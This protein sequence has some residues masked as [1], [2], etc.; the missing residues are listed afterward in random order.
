MEAPKH[1]LFVG[2]LPS[3]LT[4]EEV[5]SVFATYGNC[6][7]CHIMG[8]KATSGQACAFIVYEDADAAESAISA[9]NNVYSF[10]EDGTPPVTV[11]WARQGGGKG[12]GGDKGGGKGGPPAHSQYSAPQYAA[13]QS[14][15]GGYSKPAYQQQQAP[16][17]GFNAP[18][19]RGHGGHGGN[20]YAAGGVNP[21]PPPVHAASQQKKLFVG[22]LPLD[23]QDEAINMVFSHYGSVTNIHIMSGKSRSGQSCAFVE[24]G[25]PIE[26][27]TAI[28][29]LNE[30]YEIRPGE[31]PI[32]VK[33]ATPSAPRS[34][35]Y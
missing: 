21:P 17:Y 11:S 24:Y 34:A 13:P 32:L 22:N 26:A 35:P 33:Y 4:N 9:L 30:K 31:G 28:L 27:E 29:T 12:G 6:T 2:N 3:D 7:D 18:A 10:R 19:Q 5:Q 16:A 8:G 23:I 25:A 20:A 1:K 14:Y 15:G